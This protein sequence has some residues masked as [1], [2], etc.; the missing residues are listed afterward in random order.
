M[1]DM[2]F[3]LYGYPRHCGTSSYVWLAKDCPDWPV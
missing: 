2:V 1:G 3:D